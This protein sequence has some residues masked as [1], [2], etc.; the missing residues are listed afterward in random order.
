MS[1]EAWKDK[2]QTVYEQIVDASPKEE[3][4]PFLGSIITI[5]QYEPQEQEDR[6]PTS[7]IDNLISEKLDYFVDFVD[8]KSQHQVTG[9]ELHKEYAMG[10]LKKMLDVDEEIVIAL[11]KSGD[12]QEKQLIKQAYEKIASELKK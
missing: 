8:N 3:D 1:L 10:A 7:H 12:E 2:L 5:L 6:A 4:I 11:Y 9:I